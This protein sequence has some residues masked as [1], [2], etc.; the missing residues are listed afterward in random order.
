MIPLL[1]TRELFSIFNCMVDKFAELSHDVET[2]ISLSL[3]FNECDNFDINIVSH[4]H[5]HHLFRSIYIFSLVIV[6][7]ARADQRRGVY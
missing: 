2:D 7:Y 1:V 6:L 4:L 3:F 5:P